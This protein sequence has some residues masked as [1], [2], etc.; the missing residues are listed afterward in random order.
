MSTNPPAGRFAAWTPFLRRFTDERANDLRDTMAL[1]H[2]VTSTWRAS[3]WSDPNALKAAAL[4]TL[5]K[6]ESFLVQQRNAG[7]PA[8]WR[9][10]IHEAITQILGLESVI[11]TTADLHWDTAHLSLK[12]QVDL[13]RFLR[14][15]QYFLAHDERVITLLLEVM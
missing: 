12:E 2:E 1:H 6:T 15:Q 5:N 13:R 14:A 9:D 8:F 11:F 4:H 7:V 3:F 10:A